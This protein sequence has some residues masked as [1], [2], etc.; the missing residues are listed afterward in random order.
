MRTTEEGGGKRR[1]GGKE[2]RGGIDCRIAVKRLFNYD[3]HAADE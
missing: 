2:G 3:S 1:E